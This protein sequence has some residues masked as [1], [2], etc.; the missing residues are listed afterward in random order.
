M[1]LLLSGAWLL[2]AALLTPPLFS[3]V[4]RY[5]IVHSHRAVRMAA[6]L[7]ATLPYLAVSACIR[8][9]LLP[10]GDSAT[11]PFTRRSLHSLVGNLH[12]VG[13]PLWC[14]PRILAA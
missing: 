14:Y 8:S 10:P 6:D 11:H 2:T 4:R 9:R 1:L 12:V 7:F 13:F 5:P 3:I